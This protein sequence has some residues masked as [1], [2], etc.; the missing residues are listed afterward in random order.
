MRSSRWLGLLPCLVL[1]YPGVSLALD[2]RKAMYVGGT[3]HTLPDGAEGKTQITN[4]V[5]F[6][7]IAENAATLS[8]PWTSIQDL[9]YGRQVSRR[10]KAA[11]LK[12]ALGVLSR[13]QKHYVTI[14]YNDHVGRE[15]VAVFQ[16]G[17][18]VVGATIKA[19]KER[20]GKPLACQDQEAATQL[21]GACD[22]VLEAGSAEGT[23][24]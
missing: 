20:S 14:T 5:A 6:V 10:G 12:S 23:K 21:A 8:F 22:S 15:Q 7:F 2:A 3:I 13:G 24:K 18:E 1:A 11:A 17:T 16:L 4:P 9:E 19:L